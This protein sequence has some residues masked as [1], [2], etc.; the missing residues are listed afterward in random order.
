MAGKLASRRGSQNALLQAQDDLCAQMVSTAG[1]TAS[2]RQRRPTEKETYR[3]S[4]S[5]Q[6]PDRKI[7][8][9]AKVEKHN[10]KALR[11]KYQMNPD[12]FDDEPTELLSEID[13]D[14]DT[15]FSHRSVPLKPPALSYSTSKTPPTILGPKKTSK[16]ITNSKKGSVPVMASSDDDNN[17][18]S[19]D[20]SDDSGNDNGHDSDSNTESVWKGPNTVNDNARVTVSSKHHLEDIDEE[21]IPKIVKGLNGARQRLKA[22]DFD[23]DTK[24][25]LTTAT[26]IYRCLIVTRTPFPE[27]L[28]VETKVAKHAWRDASDVTGFT[29]QLTPSLVKMMTK[30]TSHV[31]GELKTKMRGLTA[32]FFGFRASRS[33]VAI[34]ANRDLAEALKE[35][36]SFAFKDWETKSGIYKS[37]LIQSGINYM[38][39]A[40]C[41][42]EGIV[43]ASYFDPLSVK[44]IALVL[45]V[46]ECCID[47]WLTG[48]REDIKFTSVTYSPVYML[49]L[50]S[51]RRFE[52]RTAP[53]KLL[54]R[55]TDNLLDVARFI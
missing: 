38:W 32:S 8:L 2:G 43:Y 29:V 13:R 53:Y 44:M 25:V 36:T 55:I 50:E 51:L 31:R 15:M 42:D 3:I 10:L 46:I 16:V 41:V 17:G 24:H 12:A 27:S 11:T 14:E 48:V 28:I 37:D 26:S 52:D 54:R 30:R 6:G 39:F 4:K 19:N 35:G 1:R 40:N 21:N 45:A 18:S 33:T 47:E 34:Q 20:K 23:D 7:A 9:Q 49:H 5:R 22:G